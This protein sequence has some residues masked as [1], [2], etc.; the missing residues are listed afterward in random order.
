MHVCVHVCTCAP[1][2]L[3]WRA[4]DLCGIHGTSA[5]TLSLTLTLRTRSDSDRV[6]LLEGGT[7]KEFDTP[8]ALMQV[9]M[10][11]WGV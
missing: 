11:G 3:P 9:R 6:L 1:N 10:Y 2:L 4:I 8:H 7:L 5:H